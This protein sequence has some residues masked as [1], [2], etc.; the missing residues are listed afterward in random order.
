MGSFTNPGAALPAALENA[1]PFQPL[2]PEDVRA[3]L[4]KA[5][6]FISIRL[7]H[8]RGVHASCPQ[9]ETRIPSGRAHGVPTHLLGVLR[10]HHEGVQSLRC[11]RHDAL[12]EPKLLRILPFHKQRRRPRRRPHCL[13]NEHRGLHVAGCPSC[14][15][16][17]GARAR[18]ARPAPLPP[19]HVHERANDGITRGTG[20]AVI[21]GTTSEAMLVTLV[22][23]RDAA[24]R[25]S[26]SVGVSGLNRLAVYASDQTH[27]TFF[28]ACRLAGFDPANMR[29]ILTGP[30]TQY[31]LDPTQLLR[32]MQSDADSGLV[33]TY[34]VCAT[35]GTT[36]SHAF[37]PVRAVAEVA[38]KY[39]AW[40]HLD[41]VELVDSIN[42]S[43][44]KWFQTCLDCTCL[45]VRDTHRVTDC[46]VTSPEYLK[47]DTTDSGNVT[48]LKDMQVGVG[49]RFRGLKLWMVMWTYGTAKLQE[50]IR[51]DVAMAK[52]FE[53]LV[54]ADP[55]FEVVVPRKFAL[56]CFRMKATGAM[57]EEDADEENR[58]LMKN[59]N[60]T[61]KAYVAHTMVGHM[62]VLRFEVGSSLQEERHMTNAW[63]LIKKTTDE[64]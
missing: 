2:N 18:L 6:D 57:T 24:L 36:F 13:R 31:G 56:V 27:T 52:V 20:G 37:D 9:R 47:N 50:H 26:G 54:R 35:V 51:S 46:M 17:G 48:D 44:H 30:E 55:R 15:R 11:P 60:R 16:D 53:A 21:I 64:M 28:K 39:S 14:Y 33:P 49:R 43:P 22:T 42:V 10:C 7:L 29:S 41:S 63:E 5:I 59:I 19:H 1:A 4:H 61:G 40:C 12:G 45:Y 58:A 32:A 25:R 34:V 38:A 8:Q 23:S 62:F 3:Y